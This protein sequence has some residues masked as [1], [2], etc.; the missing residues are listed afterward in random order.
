MSETNAQENSHAETQTRPYGG[1][2]PL[3]WRWVLTTSVS[4]LVGFAAYAI[5]ADWAVWSREGSFADVRMVYRIAMVGEGV[6]AGL[7]GGAALGFAQWLVLRRYIE[8]MAAQGWVLATAVGGFLELAIIGLAGLLPRLGMITLCS[9]VIVAGGT[10]LGFVQWIVLRR[11]IQKAGWWVLANAIGWKAFMVVGVIF[12]FFVL[13]LGMSY[14]GEWAWM[15]P[16]A[17]VLGGVPVLMVPGAITGIAL[18][19]LLQ[20]PLPGSSEQSV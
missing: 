6:F 7:V 19:R 8:N 10:V 11:Y 4:L 17:Y 20:T 2:W 5:A 16:P 15:M 3:W 1:G 13:L 12:Y 14:E 18:V 9:T